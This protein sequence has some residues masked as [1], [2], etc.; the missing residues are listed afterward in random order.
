MSE[1]VKEI[2]GDR[3]SKQ[4][5]HKSPG[6]E[7]PLCLSRPGNECPLVLITL[8]A[9]TGDM[10]DSIVLYVFY[11]ARGH[12]LP[13]NIR[14]VL[15]PPP[16]DQRAVCT[17]LAGRAD[18]LVCVF[19]SRRHI[20]FSTIYRIIK[21]T[22]KLPTGPLNFGLCVFFWCNC[23]PFPCHLSSQLFCALWIWLSLSHQSGKDL[24]THWHA[25]TYAA[26]RPEWRNAERT[27]S[28]EFATRP[29]SVSLQMHACFAHADVRKA[30]CVF[31]Y[32]SL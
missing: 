4:S 12:S 5:Q 27:H 28:R 17:A 3:T 11:V 10:T 8:R 13:V 22:K 23:S 26:R 19:P 6:P 2:Q 16:G 24:C 29:Q 7:A 21:K 30:K 18:F 25:L 15:P 1:V 20:T 9:H 14:F 32:L 31:L